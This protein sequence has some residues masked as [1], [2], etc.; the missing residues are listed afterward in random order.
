MDSSNL[1]SEFICFGYILVWFPVNEFLDYFLLFQKKEPYSVVGI[2]ISL[3][4][5]R[6]KGRDSNIDKVKNLLFF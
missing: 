5:E 6:P 1:L 4:A 3:Q 2:A